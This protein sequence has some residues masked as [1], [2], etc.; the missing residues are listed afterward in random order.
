MIG[1]ALVSRDPDFVENGG[2]ALV[3]YMGAVPS[4]LDCW[5]TSI[6]LK[7][8]PLRMREHCSNARA[9]ADF[10]E[11]HSK[12]ARTHYPGLESHPQHEVAALQMDDF[13]AMISIELEDFDADPAGPVTPPTQAERGEMPRPAITPPRRSS[14]DRDDTPILSAP[15]SRA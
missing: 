6:G 3:R 11:G 9:L 12:V 15:P 8:L 7:S 2:G 14:S 13:G 4:A 1:G 10:L 5:L